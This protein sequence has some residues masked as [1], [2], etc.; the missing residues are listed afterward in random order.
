MDIR[1]HI[2]LLLEDH[3]HD[4]GCAMLFFN[5][6]Q[7]KLHNQID[8]EDIYEEENDDSYGLE[9][10]PHCTLLYGLHEEV[11]TQQVKDIILKHPISGPLYA[12]NISLFQT[13]P[14]YDVL[15]FDIKSDKKNPT[16]LQKINKELSKLPNTNKFPDYHPHMTVA[17]IKKGIGQKYVDKFKDQEFDLPINYAVYSKPDRTQDKI[18]I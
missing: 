3:K 8:T 11:T 14:D 16:I 6:S 7:N 1:K 12:Y 10:E 5:F 13:S 9:D 4:F 2:N 18:Q 17:Y 15:K